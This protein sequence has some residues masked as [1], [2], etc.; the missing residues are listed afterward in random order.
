MKRENERGFALLLVF[1]LAAA[2]AISL[3]KAMPRAAF[4]SERNKEELLI[5][6]GEQYTRAVQL[7]V[8]KFKRFPANMDELE[9]TNNI[10]FLRKKFVDPMTGK[11][12]WRLLHVNA[13]GILTDSKIKKKQ[14]KDSGPAN[15]FISLAP[16][17]D[18]SAA[19]NGAAA[20][21][22]MRRRPS[23]QS[24]I[25][26]Q[27]VAPVDPNAP[28]PPFDPNNPNAASA[29]QLPGQVNVLPNTAQAGQPYPGQ[30]YPGQTQPG[31]TPGYG[32]SQQPQ[33]G[34]PV[35]PATPDGRPQGTVGGAFGNSGFG[36][37][38]FGNQQ[39]NPGGMQGGQGGMQGGQQNGQQTAMGLIQGLLTS[40]SQMGPQGNTGT[41]GAITAGG[42]AGVASKFE[43]DSIKIY[44]DRQKYEEWEFVY[45]MKND[46]RLQQA[47]PGAGAVNPGN[48]QGGINGQQSSFGI[49]PATGFGQQPAG[50]FGSQQSAFG[51]QTA[52][53]GSQ[54]SSS[55]AGGGGFISVAPGLGSSSS[56]PTPTTPAGQPTPVVPGGQQVPVQTNP[57]QPVPVTPPQTTPPQTPPQTPPPQTTPPPAQQPNNGPN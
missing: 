45:D 5:E 34:Y 41:A 26:G 57:N 31:Y 52:G 2:I 55:S 6:R 13:L 46:K 29:G 36:N 28:P 23:D 11:D 12:E 8:T 22:A 54:P 56:P 33:Q 37:S 32:Q 14:K 42:I 24:Q 40:P 27:P 7:F 10:R 39:A 21:L 53:T 18:Q 50:A 17:L 15:D 1:M 9:K 19:N 44:N 20:N 16:T 38:G 30:P 4:E 3:Y 51:Q 35:N 43:G 49:Q 48:S 25:P 47:I